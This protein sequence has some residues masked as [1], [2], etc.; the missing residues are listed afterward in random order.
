[1]PRNSLRFVGVLFFLAL[2]SLET[3]HGLDLNTITTR[4]VIEVAVYEGFP[5][6][7]SRTRGQATGVDVAV[8]KV[9]AEKLGVNT[10]LRLFRADESL[11]DD[12][13]NQIWKGHYL[14]GGTADLMM[15]VPVDPGLAQDNEQVAI[16]APYYR[17]TI[18][19]AREPRLQD[20]ATLDQLEGERIGA[21]KLT[22]AS[23]YLALALDGS[24]RDDLVLFESVADAAEALRQ[25]SLAAVMAPRGELEGALGADAQKYAIGQMALPRLRHSGWD[26]G[27]AVRSSNSELAQ[28]IATAMQELREEGVI[29]KIFKT[30][31]LAYQP[32]SRAAM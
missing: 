11:E 13:R 9:L 16:I 26:L 15:H 23:D 27:V 24:L 3:V 31:G 2:A 17:E 25:G 1:M 6:Y 20:A 4:G 10:E 32:P 5:P 7:S 30:H 29:E 19:V 22:L 28:A 8:G 18:V 21:E 12:L 14:G